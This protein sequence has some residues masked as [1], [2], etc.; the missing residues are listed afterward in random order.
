MKRDV[1]KSMLL[2]F[3]YMEVRVGYVR[4]NINAEY[5]GMGTL[6]MYMAKQEENV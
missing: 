6:E 3:C 2:P 4:R 5:T 1:Y